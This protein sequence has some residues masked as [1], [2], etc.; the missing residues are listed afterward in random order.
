[1]RYYF[2]LGC[3]GLV[4]KIKGSITSP[5]FPTA[6]PHDIECTWVIKGSPGK[7]LLV[8]FDHFYIDDTKQ[9]N[10]DY[11]EIRDGE[12]SQSPT[13]GKFCGTKTPGKTRIVQRIGKL[14]KCLKHLFDWL[15]D[16]SIHQTIDY[17]KF[18]S[19]IGY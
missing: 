13:M 7:R 6:Y 10:G 15:S 17:D 8:W 2:V 4:N 12:S 14:Y 16:I 18:S 3:G 11:V 9:C 19:L 5:D 1:M